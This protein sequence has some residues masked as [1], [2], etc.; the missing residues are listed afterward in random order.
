MR[1]P[2]Y[3]PDGI[4]DKLKDF[5]KLG[6][7]NDIELLVEEEEKRGNQIS[8]REK[9]YKLSELDAHKNDILE[10]LKSAKNHDIED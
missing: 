1:I 6:S 3:L 4:I 7:Q 5:L 9:D 10:E 8:I 2:N